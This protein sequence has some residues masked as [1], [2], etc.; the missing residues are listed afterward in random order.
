MATKYWLSL[1]FVTTLI[2]T[3]V[4]AGPE[5]QHWQTT[6]GAKIYF[7]RAHEL[8]MLDIQV[9]FDAGSA[10]DP[11]GKNG[12]SA[13]TSSLLADGA[14][15][16]NADQISYEF[17]RLGANYGAN[18]TYDSASVSLRSLGHDGRRGT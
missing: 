14:A 2:T 16:L 7:V 13:M 6:S 17:E 15:S 11:L 9:T 3:P 4:F 8:P 1:V 18:A 10:R 12:L 5:I